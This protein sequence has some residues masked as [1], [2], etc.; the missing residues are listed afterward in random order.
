MLGIVPPPQTFF[1]FLIKSW[2]LTQQ[3]FVSA[4]LGNKQG[5][6]DTDKER[7]QKQGS[8][9]RLGLAVRGVWILQA[10]PMPPPPQKHLGN[11]G[12]S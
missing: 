11:C 1:F 10:S 12:G 6:K 7:S 9:Y 8:E 4:A 5:V 3:S 2:L